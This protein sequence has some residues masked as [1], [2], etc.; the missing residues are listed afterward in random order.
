MRAYMQVNTNIVLRYTFLAVIYSFPTD[1][2]NNVSEKGRQTS[3]HASP[4]SESES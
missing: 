1:L 3:E 2:H 4:Q